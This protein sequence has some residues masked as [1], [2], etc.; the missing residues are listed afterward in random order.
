MVHHARDVGWRGCQ[1]FND[2]NDTYTFYVPQSL[3]LLSASK[4]KKKRKMKR[5]GGIE[6]RTQD[7]SQ[8]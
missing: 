6:D 7:L 8:A 3:A 5:N 2:F 4:A 1:N